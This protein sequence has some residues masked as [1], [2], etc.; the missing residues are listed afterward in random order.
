MKK[1]ALLFLVFITLLFFTG[2]N[3]TFASARKC[4]SAD[5]KDEIKEI[6]DNTNESTKLVCSYAV[7]DKNNPGNYYANV[8][9]YDINTKTFTAHSTAVISWGWNTTVGTPN[10]SKSPF[11][12]KDALDNLN[13]MNRCPRYSYIDF[14]GGN[15]IC[16]DSNGTGCKK[17]EE[18]QKSSSSRKIEFGT[19]EN[20]KLIDDKVSDYKNYDNTFKGSCDKDNALASQYGGF[21]RYVNSDL[22]YILVYYNDTSSTITMYLRK[23][24]KYYTI[25]NGNSITIGSLNAKKSWTYYNEINGLKSCPSELYIKEN[26]ITNADM[27]FYYIYGDKSLI[28]EDIIT[29]GISTDYK[30]NQCNGNS[31]TTTTPSKNGCELIPSK[32]REYIN[33]AM[34]YIRIAVPILLVGLIIFDFVSALFAASEDKMKKAQGKILKRIIIAVVIFFVPTLINLLFNI[35]ND[36]WSNANYEICGLDK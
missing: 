29:I 16:F 19:K 3:K 5:C 11:I 27:Y 4:K 1:K 22:D 9:L 15:E 32:I 21:C 25:L 13:N 14:S 10:I 33:T 31:S 6:S 35:V 12:D 28:T 23:E 17:I 30:L 24:N 18:D 8:I 34:T 7:E 20:S 36:V 26:F 2:S